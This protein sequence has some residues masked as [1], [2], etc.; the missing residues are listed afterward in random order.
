[1]TERLVLLEEFVVRATGDEPIGEISRW[2]HPSGFGNSL[3]LYMPRGAKPGIA[4]SKSKAIERIYAAQGMS[5][6][7]VTP[8]PQ[9]D[10]VTPDGR[11]I[12]VQRSDYDF[13]G[14]EEVVCTM[15][16][17]ELCGTLEKLYHRPSR[18]I[19]WIA[20]NDRGH[21]SEHSKDWEGRVELL[22]IANHYHPVEEPIEDK[23]LKESG[24]AGRWDVER[25]YN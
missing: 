13:R 1:M 14:K 3:Y 23:D 18:S 10:T 25:R 21:R 7:I 6:V 9:A 2:G 4:T 12:V 17:N 20:T 24:L 19:T 8:L 22:K 16:N 11:E 5:T 15:C